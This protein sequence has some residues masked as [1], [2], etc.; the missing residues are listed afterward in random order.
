[1]KKWWNKTKRNPK[2]NK[3]HTFWEFLLDMLIWIPEILFL[4]FRIIFWL[5]RGAGKIM[6]N[7]FDNI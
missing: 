2:K 5:F 3:P 4:P 6:G 7:L 1:M